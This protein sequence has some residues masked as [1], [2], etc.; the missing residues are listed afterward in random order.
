MKALAGAGETGLMQ[1]VGVAHSGMTTDEFSKSVVD[2]LA[3]ARHP[4]F[5]RPY[6]ELTYQPMLEL[7]ALLRSKGFKTFI[8]SAGG[9]E[10]MRP[11]TESHLQAS[12]SVQSA[13]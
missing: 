4:R 6:T 9:V 12:A 8:V 7:L 2:W 1:I 3:M 13:N 11:W 5:N 10:F